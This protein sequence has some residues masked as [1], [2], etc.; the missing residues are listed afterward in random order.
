MMKKITDYL[1]PNILIVFGALLF[2]YYLNFLSYG[3]AGIGLGISAIIISAY[4]LVIG[5]LIILMGNKISPTAQ[6]IFSLLSIT[7]FALF[8]FVYFLIM[9]VITAGVMG[10]TAWTIKILSM[11]ASLAFIVIYIIS[12]FSDK[13]VL[14]RL[15][16]LFSLVFVLALLLDLLFD[17]TGASNTLGGM[18]VLLVVIYSVYSFY[19]FGSLEKKEEL[20]LKTEEEPKK[21]ETEQND[22]P[23]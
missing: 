16:Y 5:I 23:F 13:Q 17:A 15:A 14:S 8:M 10:P 7:L 12:K 19:L 3:G 9:T 2:I 21:E 11:V 18:D 6:K 20:P 4:Y 1:K 22:I